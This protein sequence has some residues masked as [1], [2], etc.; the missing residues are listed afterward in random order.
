MRVSVARN[1]PEFSRFLRFVPYLSLRPD[2]S[3]RPSNDKMLFICYKRKEMQLIMPDFDARS[4]FRNPVKRGKKI[5]ET[6]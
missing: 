2:R 5:F 1:S 4:A 6:L 3:K